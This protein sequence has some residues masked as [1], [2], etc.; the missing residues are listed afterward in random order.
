[1]PIDIQDYTPYLSSRAPVF[2]Q[3]DYKR[4]PTIGFPYNGSVTYRWLNAKNKISGTYQKYTGEFTLNG[5]AGSL[6]TQIGHLSLFMLYETA[7]TPTVTY[8]TKSNLFSDT[9]KPWFTVA[10]VTAD[11]SLWIRVSWGSAGLGLW[12]PYLEHPTTADPDVTIN[13]IVYK[14]YH[15]D[16]PSENLRESYQQVFPGVSANLLPGLYE[17]C[18]GGN[19]KHGANGFDAYFYLL[20]LE[21][22][23]ENDYSERRELGKRTAG[24][25]AWFED[26][27]VTA[28]QLEGGIGVNLRWRDH[29]GN[30]LGYDTDLAKAF[31]C[32]IEVEPGQGQFGVAVVSGMNITTKMPILAS[33]KNA[34]PEVPVYWVTEGDY[35][36][37]N[38]LAMSSF[39]PAVDNGE[40]SIP[41]IFRQFVKNDERFISARTAHSGVYVSHDDG[42]VPT[43]FPA[44]SSLKFTDTA[45]LKWSVVA[46]TTD[47]GFSKG[48]R[49]GQEIT[50]DVECSWTLSVPQNDSSISI[51]CGD[52]LTLNY[53]GTI[54]INKKTSGLG[55]YYEIRDYLTVVLSFDEDNP[56]VQSTDDVISLTFENEVASKPVDYTQR[57]WFD[58][59]N[60][61]TNHP[62]IEAWVPAQTAVPALQ[63][64][65]DDVNV[66]PADTEV[67]NFNETTT[68]STDLGVKLWAI[69][70]GSGKRSVFGSVKKS[71]FISPQPSMI[72]KW[73]HQRLQDPYGAVDD[74]YTVCNH[75]FCR[76]EQT[77]PLICP[78]DDTLTTHHWSDI[79][80]QGPAGAFTTVDSPFLQSSGRNWPYMAGATQI[81]TSGYYHIDVTQ[82]YRVTKQFNDH[83]PMG[84]GF[85]T[86]M[87]LWLLV[88]RDATNDWLLANHLDT[89]RLYH[90]VRAQN[91]NELLCLRGTCQGSTDIW[92]NENDKLVLLRAG[93]YE[94]FGHNGSF[95]ADK[96]HAYLQTLTSHSCNIHL[97]HRDEAAVKQDK[98]YPSG[99]L[100]YPDNINNRMPPYIAIPFFRTYY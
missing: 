11:N 39:W 9:S 81:G 88:Y 14:Q 21:P 47:V 72:A 80:W 62:K 25:K 33:Q 64:Q 24:E 36:L 92:L 31:N 99:D 40:D 37:D 66:G 30:A 6:A 32:I 4:P 78:V 23:Y 48:Y 22:P 87:T 65:T 86:L 71:D 83:I 15:I 45:S 82:H 68:T 89:D 34:G 84:Y 53:A 42:V 70:N 41:V 16:V 18:I 51:G 94:G 50:A 19:G 54:S 2:G 91:I 96:A 95:F 60:P 3:M 63:I 100:Y 61:L 73:W 13:G 79:K 52:V 10:E 98:Y 35:E 55:S 49:K 90:E 74:N 97:V 5:V 56:I 7:P 43:K 1:M 77:M 26:E 57:V 12:V 38:T 28:G 59:Q 29:E 76:T 27:F 8:A 75:N 93:F 20:P 69:D 58:L 46:D 85:Y 17:I 44:T 67:L